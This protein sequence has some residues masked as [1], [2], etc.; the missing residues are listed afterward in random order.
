MKSFLPLIVLLGSVSAL[1]QDAPPP[2]QPAPAPAASTNTAADDEFTKAV[3]FGKKF[4]DLG[5]YASAV[6][7]FT[8]ADAAKPDQA[9]VLYDLALVLA[10]AGRY[11]DA[12]VKADRYNQ[13]FPNGAEKPLVAKLQLELEFQREL[14]KKRQADQEYSDLFNRAKFVYGK[15]DL[16]AAMKLFVQAEQLRPTDPAAVYN[17]AM[18]LERSGDFAKAVERYHR[19]SELESNADAKAGVDQRIF[20]LDSEIDEMKTK[21]VCS[22][23]GHRLPA[24]A[25]WCER[26]WHGPYLVESPVWNARRCADGASATRASYFA[27][28][29][30]N[31]NDV[32]P[33]LL[34]NGTMRESLRYTPARQRAIQDARRAEGWA[35]DGEMLRS[36]TDGKGNE[37]RFVQGADYLE[38]VDSSSSGDILTYVAHEGGKGVWLLDREDLIVDAQKYTNRYTFD[39]N[40]RI[41]TQQV[42]YQN[43]AACNHLI[44]MNADY[45]YQNGALLGAKI[46]GGYEGFAPEG[47]PTVRWEANVTDSYDDAARVTKEELNVT[48]FT[49]MYTQKPQG[50]LRDELNAQYQGG[51]QVK[52]T[53]TA[54]LKTGDI[55]AS[56][57]LSGTLTNAI[58]LRPF[59]VM[60]PNLSIVLPAGITKSVVSYTY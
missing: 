19:Y 30:F 28:G 49:K 33:C 7:Q 37:V 27:D 44:T 12:Q 57:G 5:E 10:K 43:A 32:L 4:F 13:L 29:H 35:Y 38:R 52:K 18:I 41:V 26:C 58:D 24:G 54:P 60:L 51:V 8:K 3:F 6:E 59:Y 45:A 15:G 50:A 22:F 40:N 46:T 1:A 23:C 56:N 48:S 34:P 17:Q 36:W 11:S 25:T 16:D 31:R 39:A 2:Q 20:A 47:S 53:L 14:Q 9:A 42:D 55:C 21:I